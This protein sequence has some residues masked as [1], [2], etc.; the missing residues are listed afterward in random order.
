MWKRFVAV[1]ILLTAVLL[2]VPGSSR[3]NTAVL[4]VSGCGS[5]FG[6]N[7]T[8]SVDGTPGGTTFNVTVNVSG[9]PSGLPSSITSIG[10]VNP[11]IGT[12]LTSAP[13][14]SAPGGTADW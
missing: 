2:L 1:T 11:K 9:T 3:A 7:F 6:L 13:L 5:S 14:T 12:G 8:L 10:A 4:T